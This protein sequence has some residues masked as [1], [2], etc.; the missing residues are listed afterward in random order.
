MKKDKKYNE[1]M[2]KI[3]ELTLTLE[4]EQRKD[5]RRKTNT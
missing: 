4:E 2:K 1:K 3:A 5:E